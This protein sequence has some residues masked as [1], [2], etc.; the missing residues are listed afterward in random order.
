MKENNREVLIAKCGTT[1]KNSKKDSKKTEKTTTKK[2]K[3][4]K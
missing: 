1:K 3:K 4:T 2:D